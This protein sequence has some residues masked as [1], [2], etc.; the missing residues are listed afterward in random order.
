MSFAIRP[1]VPVDAPSL[2]DIERA[3]GE[4][5]RALPDLAWIASDDVLSVARHLE[6]IATGTCWVAAD[7]RGQL[8]GFLSAELT[9]DA[10]HIWEMSVRPA[11]QGQGIGRALIEAAIAFAKR[12]ALHAVTLTTFRDVPWNAPFYARCGFAL[13][14]PAQTDARL[15]AILADEIA[16]G[17]PGDRRCAMRHAILAPMP[18]AR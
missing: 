6:L 12:R 2:P 15:S 13:L 5:F 10:L 17:L 14:E 3:A 11:A 18:P 8:L 7:D 4:S 9:G 16:H 1:A